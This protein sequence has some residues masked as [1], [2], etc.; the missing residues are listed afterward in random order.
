MIKRKSK[1]KIFLNGLLFQNPLLVS[2]LG[3]CP[4]LSITTSLRNAAALGLSACFVLFFTNILLSALKRIIPHNVR[5]PCSMAIIAGFVCINRYIITA[6]FPSI[7]K[8]LGI[9]LPLMAVNCMI[10]SRAENFA[11][12]NSILNSALDALGMGFGYTFALCL[13]T[14]IREFF[15]SAYLFGFSFNSIKPMTLF[16]LA[17][18][19][20]FVLGCL[21]AAVQKISNYSKKP[22]NFVDCS[23]CPAATL[24]K[25]KGD[26]V[27]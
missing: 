24:C 25:D 7:E 20:L 21:A 10:L 6:Y 8:T 22:V 17:P 18:G 2:A 13:I 4:A 26:C 9:Y 1:K 5:I 3:I 14:A 11:Y 12:K 19:G 23:N 27:K 16:I 15:G